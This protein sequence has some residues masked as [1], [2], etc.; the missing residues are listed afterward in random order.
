MP[1]I[2]STSFSTRATSSRVS[3][4][5]M[6]PRP[7]ISTA[8][9]SGFCYWASDPAD[10]PDYPRFIEDYALITGALPQTTTAAPLRDLG[11]TREVLALQSRYP[12][13]GS[14]FSILSLKMLDDVHA[15]F[16]ALELIQVGLVLQNRGALVG[17]AA[18]GRALARRERLSAAGRRDDISPVDSDQATIACVSGF[19]VGM[20]ARTVKLVSPTRACERWP[21]G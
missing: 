4:A 1:S 6:L 13:V 7:E 18:A 17:R 20:V 12:G 21:L 14:R 2:C 15:A 10:N 9:R 8:A 5:D 16:S 19:L 11:F 3:A